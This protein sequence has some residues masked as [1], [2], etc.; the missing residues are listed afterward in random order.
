[1]LNKS[2]TESF[3]VPAR[4]ETEKTNVQTNKNGMKMVI[5][6]RSGIIRKTNNLLKTNGEGGNLGNGEERGPKKRT[7]TRVPN[8]V[9]IVTTSKNTANTPSMKSG[10]CAP[11]IGDGAYVGE[12]KSERF[13]RTENIGIDYL[14]N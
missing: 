6:N 14:G 9:I 13:A 3:A 5:W 1:M 8:I 4:I 11:V 7:R 2:L 10:S 12:S